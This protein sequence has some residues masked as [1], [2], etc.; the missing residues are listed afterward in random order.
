MATTDYDHLKNMAIG[1]WGMHDTATSLQGLAQNVADSVSRIRTTL[2]ALTINDWVGKT[3]QEADDFN[4][5]WHTVMGQ[6]FGSEEKPENGVLP[7]MAGG[8]ATAVYNYDVAEFGLVDAWNTFAGKFADGSTH[9]WR[10]TQPLR[11]DNPP[12][13]PDVTDTNQTAITADYPPLKS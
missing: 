10:R 11:D 8:I 2:E 4:N 12:A 3:Q 9:K 13:P 1:P 6:M 7:A 5:Q